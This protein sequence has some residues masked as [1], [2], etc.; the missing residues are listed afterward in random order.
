MTDKRA[1]FSLHLIV[2]IW[3]FTA[4]LGALISIKAVPLVWYR[5]GFAAAF[6]G[7]FMVFK[8]ENFGVS[9]KQLLQLFG[10]GS[11]IALHWIAFYHAI[12]VAN[13]SITL[14]CLSAGAFFASLIEPLLYKRSVAWHELVFGVMMV[15]TVGFIYSVESTFVYGILI[16]LASAF[17][18]ALFSVLN[19][20]MMKTMDNPI[21]ITFYEILSGFIFVS[22][23]I[24]FT[25]SYQ[26]YDFTLTNN[27]VWY[28][29]DY[30]LLGILSSVCT[31][32]TMV[33][34]TTLMRK[35]SP[36]TLLLTV[37][38]EVIYGIVMAYFIFGSKEQ[39]HPLF[40]FGTAL[41]LL[42]L[43]ANAFFQKRL[44]PQ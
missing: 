3:G 11:L 9:L 26:S 4:I 22:I 42:I 43:V 29:N 5:M 38:L 32:Y 2:F 44:K 33:V 24:V 6:I 27:S 28:R 35:I 15:A 18:S 1:F 10:L 21:K 14:T 37:N 40:Y 12:K 17:L 13:I 25:S 34:G 39:M 8:K 30:V 20:K 23:F 7:G 31:A 36:Y 19:G 16:S 41:I